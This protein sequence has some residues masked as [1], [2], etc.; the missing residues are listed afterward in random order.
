LKFWLAVLLYQR[1]KQNIIS[2]FSEVQI[3]NYGY[4]MIQASHEQ[5]LIC[6]QQQQQ[7][8]EVH[9]RTFSKKHMKDTSYM[10][11]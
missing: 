5:R 3:S 4:E 8:P 11:V 2:G 10:M 1:K 7:Q 9:Y 6:L